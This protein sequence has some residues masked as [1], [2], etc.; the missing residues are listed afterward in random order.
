MESAATHESVSDEALLRA[1]ASGEP[2]AIGSLYAR[3]AP[4]IHGMAVSAL[5][6]AVAEEI[7]QEV[8][9]AVWTGARSFDAARG[10][11]RPWLLQISHYRIANELRR[12][13][14]KPEVAVDDSEDDSRLGRIPDPAPDQG[15]QAWL[16]YRQQALRRALENLPAPQRQALGMSFFDELSHAEIARLLGLPLGTTKARIRSGLK[17]LRVALAPLVAVLVV[18]AGLAVVWQPVTSER[19]RC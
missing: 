7:V 17:S 11:V 1:I 9:V 4:T 3:Y 5:G 18:G 13:R 19:S 14:R 2:D 10:P 15:E 12:R 16:T 6:R 8:F